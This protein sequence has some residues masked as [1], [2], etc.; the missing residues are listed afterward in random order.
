MPFGGVHPPRILLWVS[1]DHIATLREARGGNE[2]DPIE[3]AIICRKC[4][5]NGI[6]AHLRQDRRHVQDKDVFALKDIDRIKF[7]LKIPLSDEIIKT[8]IKAKPDQ[9]T[10][11]PEKVKERTTESGLDV[12]R[13]IVEIKNTVK[14][15][16]DQ[17]ILVSLFVEPDVEAIDLSKECEAD[18]IEINTGAYCNAVDKAMIDEEIG[19]IYGAAKHAGKVGLAVNAGHGLNYKN[20]VPL[21]NV[22]ELEEVNIGHSIISR[23][24]FIGLSRAVEEMLDI[25]E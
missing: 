5:C 16:H 20:I 17:N 10:I 19:R 13:N 12:R 4:G 11:V 1:I 6:T 8:A 9:I 7:N 22:T 21:L 3:A 14:L 15:F 2:P 23:S 24:V 18:L 25:L